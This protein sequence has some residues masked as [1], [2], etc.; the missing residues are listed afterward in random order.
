MIHEPV[1]M[2]FVSLLLSA[3]LGGFLLIRNR[4]FK[5]K[6]SLPALLIL[7]SIL[8]LISMFRPGSYE[9]SDLSIH[10][11]FA[12]IFFQSLREGNLFPAWHSY[13]VGGYGYPYFLFTYPLPYYLTSLFHFLGIPFISSMKLLAGLSFSLSGLAMYYWIKEETKNKIAGFVA[14]I[15]Y[16]F[17]PYHLLDLHFRFAIG[18]ILAFAIL[19]AC[20]YFI[21]KNGKKGI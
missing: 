9:S 6:I 10:S 3:L 12:I 8:P 19:P 11:S 1:K 17:A 16:L 4:V 5:K 21:K 15:F 2:V 20:F 13:A 7:I 14:G 18:E